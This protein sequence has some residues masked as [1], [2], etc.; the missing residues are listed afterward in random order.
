MLLC[1]FIIIRVIVR[2]IARSDET[3]RSVGKR[4]EKDAK[5]TEL[6]LHEKKVLIFQ[7]DASYFSP[8]TDDVVEV[9]FGRHLIRNYPDYTS[10]HQDTRYVVRAS[11]P[12]GYV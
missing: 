10:K 8:K 5:K 12:V 11:S 9:R 7:R 6:I 4:H 3:P 1:A 2:I